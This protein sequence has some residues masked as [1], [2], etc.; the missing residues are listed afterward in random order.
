MNKRHNN[1][2]YLVFTLMLCGF[3]LTACSS[4]DDDVIVDPEKEVTVYEVNV[5]NA[6]NNQPLSPVAVIAHGNNFT[7]WT[8]GNTA[9]TELEYLAEGGSNSQLLDSLTS[10]DA[11]TASGA[12]PIGPGGNETISITASGST[13][14]LLTVVT[15]LVNTNDAFSGA[16]SIDVSGL[17][18][19]DSITMRTHIYDAGTEINS[20]SAGTIPGPADGGEGFNAARSDIIDTV[21]SHGGVV[22]IDDGLS[23]SVLN[24]SHRFDNPGMIITITRI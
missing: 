13:Q 15:M 7:A 10:I 6:T 19:G 22:S 24:Q 4:S 2:W 16:S 17:A 20:E 11:S 18:K 14:T 23:T 3:F 9:S 5:I 8:V 21:R 1:P 12:A